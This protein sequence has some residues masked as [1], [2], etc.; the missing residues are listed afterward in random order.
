[1]FNIACFS[2]PY[3][4]KSFRDEL[5]DGHHINKVIDVRC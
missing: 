4:T 5:R 2:L 1:M 3:G